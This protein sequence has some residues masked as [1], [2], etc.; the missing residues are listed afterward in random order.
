[1]AVFQ[2]EL[3]HYENRIRKAE[4]LQSQ[5]KKSESKLKAGGQVDVNQ[6]ADLEERTK[7]FNKKVFT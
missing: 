1:M 7:L 6:H 4:F 2:K 5:L 3:T